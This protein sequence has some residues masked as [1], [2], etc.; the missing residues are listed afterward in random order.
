[1]DIVLSRNPL[2]NFPLFHLYV[3]GDSCVR[4]CEHQGRAEDVNAGGG[5][6]QVRDLGSSCLCLLLFLKITLMVLAQLVLEGEVPD[7]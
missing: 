7:L 3:L 5:P 6:R 1:M 4:V 2:T